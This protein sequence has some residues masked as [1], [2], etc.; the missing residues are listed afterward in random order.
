MYTALYEQQIESVDL[1]GEGRQVLVYKVAH[2]YNL[3][4]S[5]DL[6][7]WTDWQ[8]TAVYSAKKDGS[9]PQEQEQVLPKLPGIMDI[10]AV[11][12]DEKGEAL[13]Y[14]MSNVFIP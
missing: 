4:V 8:K 10:H 11:H 6:V 2:P 1:N 14:H 13:T 3:A 7:Y 5:G 12:M 9:S